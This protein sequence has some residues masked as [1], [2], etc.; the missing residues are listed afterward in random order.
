LTAGSVVA[1]GTPIIVTVSL[2]VATA[3]TMVTVPNVTGLYLWNAVK[4]L[5]N[6]GLIVEPWVYAA[7]NTVAEEYVVSQSL[8]A[9]L[10]VL[11]WS[12]INLIVSS[13]VP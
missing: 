5:V 4:A 9:G 10:S 1:V 2:G 11:A 12:P 6:A 7:S 8:A 3:P 13:G